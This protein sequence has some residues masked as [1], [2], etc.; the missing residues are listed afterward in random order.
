MP[1]IKIKDLNFYYEFHG[2]GEPLVLISGTG[3]SCEHWKVFQVPDLSKHF[4]VLIWDHRG[5]AAISQ[6]YRIPHPCLRRTA[7]I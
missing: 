4:R 2:E 1:L 3:F 5:A 6:N 7:R